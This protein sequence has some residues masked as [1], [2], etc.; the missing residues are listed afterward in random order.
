MRVGDVNCQ[1]NFLIRPD[2]LLSKGCS[3]HSNQSKGG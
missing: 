2:N 3:T 1:P